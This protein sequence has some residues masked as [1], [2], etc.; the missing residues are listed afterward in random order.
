MWGVAYDVPVVAFALTAH[1][2]E[3]S[4]AIECVTTR[5]RYCIIRGDDPNAFDTLVVSTHI[6]RR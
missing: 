5:K 1:P 6:M 4:R 2:I 3:R